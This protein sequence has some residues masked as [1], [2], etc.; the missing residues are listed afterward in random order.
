VDEG[1]AERQREQAH[2]ERHRLPAEADGDQRA[3]AKA[4]GRQDRPAVDAGPGKAN[5]RAAEERAERDEREQRSREGLIA[6]AQ[7]QVGRVEQVRAEEHGV[8][9]AEQPE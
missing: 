8:G 3:A 7:Q 1:G 9:Q 4:E 5:Q 2:G 6:H